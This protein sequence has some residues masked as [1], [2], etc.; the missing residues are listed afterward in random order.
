MRN[1]PVIIV[2]VG[3]VC[4]L[5]GSIALAGSG[6]GPDV[7]RL[8][9]GLDNVR[10]GM[11]VTELKAARPS[12]EPFGFFRDK[13]APLDPNK[14][15]QTL[16]ESSGTSRSLQVVYFKFAG[17]DLDTVLIVRRVGGAEI[18]SEVRAFLDNAVNLWGPADASAVVSLKG[19]KGE[20][21]PAPALLWKKGNALVAAVCSSTESQDRVGQ[22]SVEV[23][24]QRCK[25]EDLTAPESCAAV[26]EKMYTLSDTPADK[27]ALTLDL[28]KSRV[29]Q[30]GLAPT[31][32]TVP[33]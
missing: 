11:T 8:P 18:A 9:G 1:L 23:K 6:A 12:A 31:D 27:K 33:K 26:L 17:L 21:Q 14:P 32:G 20:A 2:V 28:V 19:L 29:K 16:F 22:G 4:L 13:T 24:V 5:L 25:P 15:D 7:M 3:V 30:T 10:L